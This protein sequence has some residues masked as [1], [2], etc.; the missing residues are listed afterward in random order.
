MVFSSTID[1]ESFRIQHQQRNSWHISL[2]PLL[3]HSVV[4]F[5]LC[6]STRKPPSFRKSMFTDTEIVQYSLR[7]KID[8]KQYRWKQYPLSQKTRIA[9]KT[10]GW[11][12]RFIHINVRIRVVYRNR[13]LIFRVQ[14]MGAKYL[15]WGLFAQSM[16]ILFNTF[17]KILRL[18]STAFTILTLFKLYMHRYLYSRH[19]MSRV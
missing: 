11:N 18:Q 6:F 7:G 15:N 12:Y 13:N 19:T 1:S 17:R 3:T 14:K 4:H 16:F 9:S 10:R 5:S 8:L 2:H